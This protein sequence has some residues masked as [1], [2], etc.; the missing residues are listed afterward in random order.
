MWTC[1]PNMANLVSLLAKICSGV[2]S[3]P[4]NFNGFSVSAS[5]LQWCRSSEANQTLHNVWPSPGSVHYDILGALAPWWNFI[6]CKIHFTSKSSILLYC[7]HY[8]MALQQRAWAELCGVVHGMELRNFCRRHHLYSA[9][10][11]SRWA[12]AHIPVSNAILH[13]TVC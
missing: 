6:W 11:P 2:W 7:Q 3:T 12:S 10:W 4:A 5:L 8:C 1:P 13:K 9:G